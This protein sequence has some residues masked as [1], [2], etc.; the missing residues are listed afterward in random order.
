MWTRTTVGCVPSTTVVFGR[1]SATKQRG[2]L[3]QKLREEYSSKP[4]R[5]LVASL[6]DPDVGTRAVTQRDRILI[7]NGM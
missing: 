5:G 7:M 3:A 2:S 6:I 1:D 4:F